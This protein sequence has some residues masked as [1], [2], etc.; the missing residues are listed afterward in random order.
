MN[1]TPPGRP[2]PKDHEEDQAGQQ[3]RPTTGQHRNA[4]PAG[5]LG[6]GEQTLPPRQTGKRVHEGRKEHERELT[7]M[8]SVLTK[9]ATAGQAPNGSNTAPKGG[10]K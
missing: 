3:E 7:A 8:Q 9:A 10:T 5:E 4:G 6:R 1:G 2:S